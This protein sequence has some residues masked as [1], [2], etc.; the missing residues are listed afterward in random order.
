MVAK[1]TAK[2]KAKSNKAKAEKSK[3]ARLRE[4]KRLRRRYLTW[5]RMMRYGVNNFTRNAWLT[6]AATA[7]MTVTLLIVFSTITARTMLND[8]VAELRQ[9]IDL[10]IFLKSEVSKKTVEE[11][12]TKLEETDNV[13]RVSFIS[14]EEG[15]QIYIDREI[16]PNDTEALQTLAESGVTFPARFDINVTNPDKLTSIEKLIEEDEQFKANLLEGAKHLD[17][18]RRSAIG[19]ISEWADTAERA[20]LIATILFVAISMLIVFNTIRMAIFNRRDEIEM[21]KLIGA[22]KAFIRGPFVVEAVMYGFFAA[23][24]ATGLGYFG[25]ITFHD[26]IAGYGV[27]IDELMKI[28]YNYSP[29]VLVVMIMLGA[30]IGVISS[31]LAV[32]RYLKV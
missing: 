5:L 6:T 16:D 24:L 19:T 22:D 28:L 18:D 21:M 32:R 14:S 3:R 31:R 2:T 15:R 8:T 13:T 30:L 26:Q 23:I 27:A 11:L 17:S 4:N 10:A 7:V 1:S 29:L 25:L 9:N 12:K 20:G